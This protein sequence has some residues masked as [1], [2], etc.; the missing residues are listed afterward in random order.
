M[1]TGFLTYI[2]K[3]FFRPRVLRKLVV[4]E[5]IYP[6]KRDC[7]QEH[8]H[9]DVFLA[10][11]CTSAEYSVNM[12]ASIWDGYLSKIFYP[13]QKVLIKIN[14]NTEDPYP[15]STCPDML[16]ELVNLLYSKGIRDIIVGDCSSISSLPTKNVARKTGIS[17]AI[18]DKARVVCF[19]NGPWVKVP[20]EGYYLKQVTIP[21]VVFEVDRIIFLSNLKTHRLADFSLGMKLSVGFMHPLERYSLHKDHL[22]EKTVEIN[23]AVAPDFTIIDG[24]KAFID[25]GP[26]KGRLEETGIVLFGMNQLYVDIE[27]YKQL[28]SFKKQGG[29]TG[30]FKENPLDMIQLAHARKIELGA[31]DKDLQYKTIRI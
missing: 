6:K 18:S 11:N 15:A 22:K 25:G 3:K 12:I 30:S 16:S 26:E 27:A 9:S 2:K 1:G 23:L 7:L 17:D 28:Y 21:K 5:V 20:I 19:D 8:G 29:C 13:G 10:G 31:K 24:R 4:R 14:M